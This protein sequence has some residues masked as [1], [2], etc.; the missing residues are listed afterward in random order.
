[1]AVLFA[2]TADYAEAKKRRPLP[3]NRRPP[4]S[5]FPPQCTKMNAALEWLYISIA[6]RRDRSRNWTYFCGYAP[7]G[8]LRL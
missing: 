6:Q 5:V 7:K 8:G 3:V 2:H 1:V 4:V